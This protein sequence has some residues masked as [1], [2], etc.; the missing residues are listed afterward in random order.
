MSTVDGNQSLNS[1]LDKLGIQ[2]QEEKKRADGGAL[3]QEDFLKL[4]TTQ[5]QNK[6]PFAPMENA[7][8]IAQMAQFS[9]VT[10]I[11]D[12]GQSLKGISNQL[13]EFRIATATNML[14]N[15]VLVPGTKAYP[16][17]NGA[18]HG[19]IDLPAASGTTNVVFSSQSGDILHIEELGAQ[20]S[21]LAGFSWEDIPQEV[22]DNNDYITVEAFADQGGG[23]EGVSTSVFGEVLAASTSS[24]DGVML[25][26]KGYGDINV[27]DVVRFRHN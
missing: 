10:G 14:G 9:T 20:P 18:V 15:S 17:G 21:G 16:D 19:V 26:V 7:D 27:N 8:F 6:D 22:L 25:D 11:T 4:M 2:P 13:S 24:A 12:M 3:G 23:L 5:L 1:I